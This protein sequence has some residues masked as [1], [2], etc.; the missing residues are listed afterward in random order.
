[1]SYKIV[2]NAKVLMST[3]GTKQLFIDTGHE[4]VPVNNR[5]CY[6]EHKRLTFDGDITGRDYNNSFELVKVSDEYIDINTIS[7]ITIETPDGTLVLDR[8]DLL[9]ISVGKMG[10]LATHEGVL[11]EPQTFIFAST[12]EY[13]PDM[14]LAPGT[15]VLAMTS[16][17]E[18]GEAV[19]AYVSAVEYATVGKIDNKF[20]PVGIPVIQYGT[21]IDTR[22][23]FPEELATQIKEVFATSTPAMLLQ[24][25][26]CSSDSDASEAH[27]DLYTFGVYKGDMV[28]W[29]AATRGSTIPAFIKID[30]NGDVVIG[31]SRS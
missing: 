27:T 3:D 20:L 28:Y 24:F 17:S 10:A 25:T 21:P 30:E 29:A 2:P 5:L 8:N 13:M 1:M 19:H 16:I 6:E 14:N 18:D 4:I 9:S 12:A 26:A 11:E 22:A 15:H 31:D 7:S 23:P